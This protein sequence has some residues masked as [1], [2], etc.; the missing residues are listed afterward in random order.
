MQPLWRP[1]KRRDEERPFICE[2][3]IRFKQRIALRIAPGGSVVSVS[4]VVVDGSSRRA[5]SY[6]TAISPVPSST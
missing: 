6:P 3:S 5:S 4:Q 2:E 1:D